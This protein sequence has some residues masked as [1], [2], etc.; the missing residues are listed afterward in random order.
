MDGPTGATGTIEQVGPTGPTG[1]LGASL[2]P[3]A[4]NIGPSGFDWTQPPPPPAY[5]SLFPS[6]ATGPVEPP[7]ITTLDE[8][9]SSHA[10]IV[11]KEAKDKQTLTILTNPGRDQY[12]PQLFQWAAIGFPHAYLIQTL[13]ITPPAICSDGETRDA[14]AY[15]QFL[16][17]PTT[18]D[19]VLES[20]RALMPG[21]SVSFSF[22]GNIFRI[23]VSKG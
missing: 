8:L 19:G 9:M 13:E 16:L 7:H 18:L 10:V 14:M 21:I 23:H 5:L 12:R 11:T 17:A 20:I 4:S 22:L 6:A 1:V 2:D 3:V 15:L